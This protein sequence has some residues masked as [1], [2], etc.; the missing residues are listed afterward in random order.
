[1][2]ELGRAALIVC[3]GL[4]VYAI[5]AGSLAAWEGR[6]RLA[7]SAQNALVAAFAAAAVASGVLAVALV[8]HDFSFVYVADFTSEKLP[9]GYTLSAFW[10][11]QAGSLLLWLLVLTGMSAL[12]VLFNRYA[13][14]EVIAW[15]VPVLGLVA[16]FF[17]FLLVAVASPFETQ[18]APADGAG[19]NPSL[20]NPYMVAHPPMLYL[21][22]VGL[23]IPFAFAMGALLA[24]RTDE[25]WIVATRRWTLAAWAF[26]GFGQLLGAHWAYV[27]VGWGGYFAWDPVENAAL[28]PWLAATA[29]LHSVMVQEKKGML[30]VWNVLLVILSFCLAIFGTFLT[31]SG[32]VNSIHSF[33][34]SS[35]G[36]WFLGF[37][38]TITLGSIALVVYRLPLLRAKTKLESAIS[39][40]AAFLYNNLL[41]VAL[42]LTILW[43]VIFPIVSEAVRGE[44]VTVGPPYFNF[45]LRAFGIPL[46]LLMGIGPLVAWR[47][48]SIGSLKRM[49]A[50]PA[51]VAVVAGGVL[52]LFG[53]GDSLPGLVT[54]T[55]S[56]FVLASIAIEFGKGTQARRA[57][58]GGSWWSAFSGLVA[59]NRRRYGGYVVHAAIVLLAIGVAGSSLYQTT[60]EAKLSPGQSLEAAGYTLTY[61]ELTREPR[62]NHTAVRAHVDVY[63][64]GELVSRLE[65]GKNRYAAEDQ[66]SS[67]MAIY[68]SWLRAEDVDVIADQ[69][70][71]DQSVY[72]KVLVKPLVNLIWLAGFVFVG[73]ALI[74]LWPDARESRRFAE[75]YERAVAVKA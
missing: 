67:E 62:S 71:A 17:A 54:Y 28:M 41:L 69:V 10:G 34:Q 45:F 73:G 49:L 15:A 11:G 23:T 46:L 61:R 43:G 14:R 39:R 1:M 47:R 75:R 74:A 65:P 31:R 70:N 64:G 13:A 9:F 55:F 44:S 24:G 4:S 38:I 53:A 52:L 18:V 27:E 7:A 60:R 2:A 56:A 12:A 3:L 21:G 51:L 68:T 25:R 37:I 48:A 59:R 6:R 26:L 8:R 42:S 66:V 63:R 19:L 35:I 57:L 58:T 16:A 5:V 30:K 40:E 32:I 22:Y 36:P 72:F 29:F 20:Q 33:T 50:W